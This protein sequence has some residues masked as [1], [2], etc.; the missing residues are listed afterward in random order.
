MKTEE[1]TFHSKTAMSYMN[2]TSELNA[3][4]E[5]KGKSII[6]DGL[7]DLKSMIVVDNS[8]LPARYQQHKRTDISNIFNTKTES[9]L[10]HGQSLQD[11]ETLVDKFA[12]EETERDLINFEKRSKE[13]R[14][15][16]YENKLHIKPVLIDNDRL[17]QKQ[18]SFC[19]ALGLLDD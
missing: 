17:Y 14:L 4:S 7:D 18:L 13:I 6:V 8:L 2:F 12:M 16:E 9:F 15:E 5:H 11:L 1:M 19:L 3:M 10:S